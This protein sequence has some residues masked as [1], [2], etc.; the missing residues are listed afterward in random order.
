[1]YFA[2]KTGLYVA[3]D[4][5]E[6]AKDVCLSSEGGGSCADVLGG[7]SGGGGDRCGSSLGS[8]LLFYLQKRNGEKIELTESNPACSRSGD[9]LTCYG[10]IQVYVNGGKVQVDSRP[11]RITGGLSGSYSVYVRPKDGAS[12][13]APPKLVTKFSVDTDIYVVWGKIK[14]EDDGSEMRDIGGREKSTVT[15]KLVP[16]AFASGAW[17]NGDSNPGGEFFVNMD[18]SPGYAFTIQRPGISGDASIT[19]LGLQIYADSLGQ[20]HYDDPF[21]TFTVPRNQGEVAPNSGSMPGLLVLWVTGDP[22]AEADFN[23]EINPERGKSGSSYVKVYMPRLAFIDPATNRRLNIVN[24]AEIKGSDPYKKRED[25]TTVTDISEMS[26]Y[27]GMDQARAVAAYDISGNGEFT[28]TSPLCTSCNFALR[29]KSWAT[30]K[31]PPVN[32][33]SL[34]DGNVLSFDGLTLK[35]GIANF[36]FQGVNIVTLDTFAFFRVGPWRAAA[37]ENM[38]SA[39]WDSLQFKELPVPSPKLVEIYDRNGDGIGDSLRIYYDKAFAKYEQDKTIRDS[40]PNFIEV[41]WD[42]NMDTPVNYGL[43]I[44]TLESDGTLKYTDAAIQAREKPTQ[45]NWN[46]WNSDGKKVEEKVENEDTTSII[47]I[48][49][50]RVAYDAGSGLRNKWSGIDL[51]FFSEGV[52]TSVGEGSV[53]VKSWATFFDTE[54]NKDITAGGTR[55]IT[56]KIPP[57]VISAKYNGQDDCGSGPS[58]FCQDKVTLTL[59]EKVKERRDVL[60]IEDTEM[61][62]DTIYADPIADRVENG[63]APMSE[64][65]FAY[66]LSRSRGI[67]EYRIYTRPQDLPLVISSVGQ[68]TWDPSGSKAKPRTPNDPTTEG[69]S[70]VVI[71]YAS[72]KEAGGDTTNTPNA[73]DSV[74]LAF[75]DRHAVVDLAGNAPPSDGRE[76]GRI[77]EGKGRFDYGKIP[78][79]SIDPKQNILLDAIDKLCEPKGML[80]EVDSTYLFNKNKQVSIL[81]ILGDWTTDSIRTYYPGSVGHI[82]KPD[83]ENTLDGV[84]PSGEKIDPEKITFHTKAYYHTNLG[85]YVVHS[86]HAPI[87][88]TDDM[89]KMKEGVGVRNNDCLDNRMAIYVGWNLKDAKDR[90]VGAGAYVEVFDFYWQYEGK[91]KTYGPFDPVTEKIDMLGVKRLKSKK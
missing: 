38:P 57:I 43:A 76:V 19:G 16:V 61:G 24:S 9:I 80:C 50:T 64:A 2:Q 49:D 40:L 3:G 10:G 37:L 70:T 48:Y 58:K 11:G 21:T 75:G 89:F 8:E 20:K 7:G 74:Q 88:C 66:Q 55:R 68:M 29:T 31:D 56:D 23:Y 78:I 36:T 54:V 79:A 25:G 72:Y 51:P 83:I 15:G 41:N 65:S 87:K 39:K 44:G 26:V 13:T 42:L 32:V 59:S 84:L 18:T 85:S 47:V 73:R 91:T 69:D 60:R 67:S 81:P 82:Y 34:V 27:T 4:V 46:Y 1:M 5:E 71:Y 14:N 90:W 22:R 12:F 33:P 77:F 30:V 62:L 35:N 52:K 45:D 86:K 6:G 63:S 28:S 17:V 53:N